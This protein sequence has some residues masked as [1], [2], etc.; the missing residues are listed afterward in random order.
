VPLVINQ[1]ALHKSPEERIYQYQGSEKR[2]FRS[3]KGLEGNDLGVT[4]VLFFP[5][6]IKDYNITVQTAGVLVIFETPPPEY[7]SDALHFQ[8]CFCASHNIADWSLICKDK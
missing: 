7:E 2:R 5:A 3:C 6:V 1:P 4:A 8:L